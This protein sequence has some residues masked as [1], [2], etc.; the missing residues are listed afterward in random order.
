MASRRIFCGIAAAASTLAAGGLVATRPGLA[1]PGSG[2]QSGA[3]QRSGHYVPPI[4]FGLGGVPLGNEFE[5][6]TDE[7]AY[8][9]LDAAWSAGVRYYDVS[10]W[11]GL[12]LAERRFGYYLHTKNRHQNI[13]PCKV[14]KLLKASTQNNGRSNFPFSPSPNNV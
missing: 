9:T 14:G 2:M 4:K 5:V 13:L 12:G 10:P 8:K 11:Y 3:G 6:I 7:E 1:A